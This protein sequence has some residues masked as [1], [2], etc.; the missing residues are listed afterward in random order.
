MPKKYTINT[1]WRAKA[2]SYSALADYEECPRRYYLTKAE[3]LLQPKG[4]AL[5]KGIEIHEAAELFLKNKHVVVPE[6]LMQFEKEMQN[7]STKPVTVEEVIV[8]DRH[9]KPIQTTDPDGGWFHRDA[10][11]RGRL[12]VRYGSF[13]VD[14]KTGRNY[15]K[16]REQCELYATMVYQVDPKL[17]DDVEVELWFTKSGD[18][19]TH[20]FTKADQQARLEAWDS[21]ASK[22]MMEEKWTATL[23]DAC[24][25]CHV[26]DHCPHFGAAS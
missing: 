4:P 16:Y 25:F 22:L 2:W 24:R 10:W 9:W 15:P 19:I 14:F 21:R 23:N 12:D 17:E 7:L 26:Q 6:Q 8:L 20:S 3:K 11:L 13:V 1:N 18:V 5:S